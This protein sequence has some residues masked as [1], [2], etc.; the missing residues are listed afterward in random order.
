[1]FDGLLDI[2]SA[3]GCL[4]RI[5]AFLSSAPLLD[6]RNIAGQSVSSTHIYVEAG[7]FG[8]SDS[9]VL[10]NVN[11]SVRTGEIVFLLGPVAS[12]KTTLLNAVLGETNLFEGSVTMASSEIAWCGQSP[13][14]KV[15]S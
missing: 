4:K 12:G 7:V 10:S 9:A 5:E 6:K 8:W 3:I 15:R 11:I 13:W 14:L 1:M 2:M